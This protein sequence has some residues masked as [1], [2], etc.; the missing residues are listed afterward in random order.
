VTLRHLGQ[1]FPAAIG[2][3]CGG[4]YW[5]EGAWSRFRQSARRVT[6]RACSQ[7]AIVVVCLPKCARRGQT[8]L[9]WVVVTLIGPDGTMR[10]RMADPPR[11]VTLARGR[12]SS[13][14]PWPPCRPTAR[15][16]EVRSAIFASMTR[17]SWSPS[18][19]YPGRCT[20]WSLPC[21]LSASRHIEPAGQ[22][23]SRRHFQA[24]GRLELCSRKNRRCARLVAPR[25]S[26][27]QACRSG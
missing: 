4:R 5:V 6:G 3:V 13:H 18:R 16:R 11:P 25:S 20:T 19:T 17:L 9:M 27:A 26:S 12:N 15:F 14:G 24:P 8:E 22:R 10:R 1:A 7:A 2:E 21:W 23:A